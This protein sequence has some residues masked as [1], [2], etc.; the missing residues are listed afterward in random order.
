MPIQATKW[1][2]AHSHLWGCN[3]YLDNELRKKVQNTVYVQC[4]LKKYRYVL[5]ILQNGET[6]LHLAARYG[7]TNVIERLCKAKADVNLQDKVTNSNKYE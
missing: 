3:V 4:L 2:I 5:F 1:F 6:A 7:Q